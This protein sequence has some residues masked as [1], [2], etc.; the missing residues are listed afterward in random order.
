MLNI[1]MVD[2]NNFFE[3]IN[4]K[5]HEFQNGFIESNA[6]SIAE[7]KYFSYWQCVG[8]YDGETLVGFAMYGKI[9]SEGGR[10]WL[11]R[12]MIDKNFQG[13]GYGSRFLSLL[14][15][16]IESLYKN[17]EIYL[18]IYK[19]NINAVKLYEK[20]GFKFNGE[21]DRDGECVMCKTL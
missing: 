10:V 7:S 14:I 11:D 8:L 1:K 12:Y 2:K 6:L 15:K 18:S 5:T 3:V 9:D 20:F 13:K 16:E 17:S 4:L 21:F 19:N